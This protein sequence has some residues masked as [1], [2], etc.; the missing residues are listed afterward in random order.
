[1]RQ[2]FVSIRISTS[3]RVKGSP[4]A[5]EEAQAVLPSGARSEP[6]LVRRRPVERGDGD[7]VEPQVDGELP[8][9]VGEMVEGAVADR[10]VPRLLGD[11]VAAGEHP[12]GGHQVLVG[13]AGEGRPRLVR[14][15]PGSGGSMTHDS[16]GQETEPGARRDG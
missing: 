15:L 8:P 2:V 7:V 11:H 13:G 3:G 16:R 5:R 6:S 9:V 10:D 4:A 14:C 1:L 12:P